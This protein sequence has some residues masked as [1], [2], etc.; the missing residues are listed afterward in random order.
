MKKSLYA[1][2]V[3]VAASA[4]AGA[5]VLGCSIDSGGPTLNPQPLPPSDPPAEG[6]GEETRDP[7]SL[8]SGVDDDADGATDAGADDDA[9]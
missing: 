2:T 3:L 7:G 8:G 1:L 9:G 4:A 6:E 5:A